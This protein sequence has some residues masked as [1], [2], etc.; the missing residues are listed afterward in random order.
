M[1]TKPLNA[2]SPEYLAV[3]RERDE[4]P[5][6]TD[7]DVVGPWTLREQG[8]KFYIFREWQG[9]ET[10]H[11]P[12]AEF[13]NREDGLL[14]LTALRAIAAEPAFRVRDPAAGGGDGCEVE[15]EG[16]KVARFPYRR[17]EWLV[18]AHVLVFLTRSPADLAMLKEISGSQVQEMAGE[19]LAQEILGGRD[20]EAGA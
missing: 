7:G 5:S 12:L 3:L 2:F 4:P 16:V 10:G 11:L 13:S 8:G 20:A 6:A 18:A 19:I 14:F 1:K 9:F 15:R 17:E